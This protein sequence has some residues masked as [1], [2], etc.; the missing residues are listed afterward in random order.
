MAAL[1]RGDGWDGI[2]EPCVERTRALNRERA[3]VSRE[4][5]VC[6]CVRAE[7]LREFE[8]RELAA[9]ASACPFVRVL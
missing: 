6:D 9:R 8:T 2:S 1:D 7:T 5:S 4:R 3:S